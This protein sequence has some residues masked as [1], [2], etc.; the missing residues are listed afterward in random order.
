MLVGDFHVNNEKIIISA[1]LKKRID[2]LR[3]NP[4]TKK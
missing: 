2:I 4:N 1:L 3:I